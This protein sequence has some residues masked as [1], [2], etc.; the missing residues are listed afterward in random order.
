MNEANAR[1]AGASGTEAP[2]PGTEDHLLTTRLPAVSAPPVSRSVRPSSAP[3]SPSTPLAPTVE[4]EPPQETT[5]VLSPGPGVRG[6]Q[7]EAPL[8]PEARAA[9]EQRFVRLTIGG[10]SAGLGLALALSGLMIGLIVGLRGGS[11]EDAAAASVAA[12]VIVTRGFVALGMLA[13]GSALMLFAAMLL[14]GP[15]SFRTGTA[16]DTAHP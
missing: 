12:A 4:S 14:L 10:T 6:G 11:T 5:S 15:A 7:R 3:L 8:S 9:R 16:S 2:A 13:F 1:V